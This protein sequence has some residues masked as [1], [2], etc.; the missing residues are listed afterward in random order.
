MQECIIKTIQTTTRYAFVSSFFFF[1]IGGKADFVQICTQTSKMRYHHIMILQPTITNTNHKTNCISHCFL[2]ISTTTF[3]LTVAYF[4]IWSIIT[5]WASSKGTWPPGV[6][7]HDI[8]V[9]CFIL[10]TLVQR[11]FKHLFQSTPAAILGNP[12]IYCQSCNKVTDIRMQIF[13]PVV[14]F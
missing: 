2:H 6:Y 8:S 9:Y 14:V 1:L 13:S 7:W 10:I 11:Q 4:T 5:T 12:Q 3:C